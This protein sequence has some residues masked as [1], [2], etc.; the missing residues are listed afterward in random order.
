MK[1]SKKLI[2][3]LIIILLITGGV[4][5]YFRLVD[6][7]RIKGV[8]KGVEKAGESEDIAGVM[9]FV[10]PEYADDYGFNN[11]MVKRLLSGLSNDFDGFKI[12]TSKPSI[13]IE[14]STAVVSCSLWVTVAWN[15]QPAYLT[16]SNKEGAYVRMFLHQAGLWDWKIIKIEGIKGIR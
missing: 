11:P 16:G 1:N 6:L 12:I 9:A 14:G 4:V 5:H 10:S 7:Y 15:G 8:L 13:R 3:G 2:I